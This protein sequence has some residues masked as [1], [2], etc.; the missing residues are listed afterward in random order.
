[1]KL[2][3]DFVPLASSIYLVHLASQRAC[4]IFT[5]Q[6]DSG[7]NAAAAAGERV[8]LL[9]SCLVYR[10]GEGGREGGQ[11]RRMGGERN[12]EDGNV[13]ACRLSTELY[14][15]TPVLVCFINAV[16]A[17]RQERAINRK[18]QT[19]AGANQFFFFFFILFYTDILFF[20]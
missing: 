18:P 20:I 5:T 17:V 1:M 6:E 2:R 10:E 8:H 16:M 4:G 9:R 13:I 7:R 12:G 15:F 11:E 3:G 14:F 19:T